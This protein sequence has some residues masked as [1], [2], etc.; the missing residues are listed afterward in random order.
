VKKRGRQTKHKEGTQ[1]PTVKLKKRQEEKMGRTHF[2][3]HEE[4]RGPN[5]TRRRK[6]GRVTRSGG[7]KKEQCANVGRKSGT[8]QC[9]GQGKSL[10]KGARPSANQYRKEKSTSPRDRYALGG[11][12]PC[13]IQPRG[14]KKCNAG[15]VI[16]R[17]YEGANPSF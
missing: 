13:K 10:I 1:I 16:R 11:R 12:Q 4:Y 14:K 2:R 9:A 6:T 15:G 17:P 8:Q 3:G 5:A 7:T